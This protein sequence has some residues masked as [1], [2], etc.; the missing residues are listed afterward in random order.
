MDRFIPERIEDLTP[1]WLTTT[2]REGGHLA[3]AVTVTSA[4]REI[5]GEGEGF[6]GDIVRLKLSYEGGA[7]PASVVAKMPRLENRA[8][9][10]LVGVYERESCF[11]EEFSDTVPV[12][13]PRLYHSDFD[14]NAVSDRQKGTLSLANRL[15][16]RLMPRV[17]RMA[18]WAAGRRKR[19]YLL[20]LEDL[21]DATSGDQL[22]GTDADLC[23]VVLRSIAEMHAALWESPALEDRYWL[24]P[25][26]GDSRVRQSMF[27][28]MLGTFQ[29]RHPELFDEEFERVVTWVGENGVETI[30][31]M[32]QE[33]P[34]TFVHGDLRLDNLVFRG[35]EPV[36]FDWQAIRRGPAAYDVAWFLSGAS[37]DLTPGDEAELLRTYHATLEEHGVSGYPFEAFERHYRL[38]LLTTVQTLGLLTI[39]DISVGENRG[40]DMARAWVRRL[41]ARLETIDLDRV[42]AP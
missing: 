40:A 10:E 14:R 17:T 20:L 7:G 42:L 30:E 39:L 6:M 13:L 21:G 4:E 11:Y 29:E 22:A 25:L 35:D 9:G 23:A 37:D 2:L 34:E 5:L 19:R 27:L 3:P 8:F 15:P 36:F 33:A 41:R 16:K 12:A 31:R 24:V 32:Q 38:G 26:A 1:E 28:E 18:L